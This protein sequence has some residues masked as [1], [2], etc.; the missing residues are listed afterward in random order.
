MKFYWHDAAVSKPSPGTEVLVAYFIAEKED[1]TSSFCLDK[2]VFWF[3]ENTMVTIKSTAR[4]SSAY[5]K[6]TDVAYQNIQ[7]EGWYMLDLVN[8]EGFLRYRKVREPACVSRLKIT[9]SRSKKR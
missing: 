2:G 9:V 5:M 8:D 7:E 6:Q 1:D 3:P 4:T